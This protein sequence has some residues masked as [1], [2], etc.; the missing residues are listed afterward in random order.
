MSETT[1]GVYAAFAKALQSAKFVGKDGWNQQQQFKF[2]GID[3]TL[4][5]VGPAFRE[6][7]LF[8]VPEV[9]T[10][11]IEQIQSARGKPM[12][13]V[14]LHMKYTVAHQDGSSFSGT[15]VGEATDFADKA[16]SKAGSVALRTFLLQSMVLPTGDSDPD[17]EYNERGNQPRQEVPAKVYADES[18]DP[19]QATRQQLAVAI[20]QAQQ[21]GENEVAANLMAVGKRRFAPAQ[22]QATDNEGAES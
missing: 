5:A 3:G 15:A 21:D 1:G 11:H 8:L 6:N 12:V 9:V 22:Q 18:W 16:T 20:R 4:Q 2:R 13:Q 7:D 10:H 17:E 14:I 19:E